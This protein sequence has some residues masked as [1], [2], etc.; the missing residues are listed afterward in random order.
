MCIKKEMGGAGI[1]S[2][3]GLTECPVLAM[4]APSDP[5]EKLAH[6]EGRAN[7]SEFEIRVVKLDGSP[8]AAGEEGEIRARGP[9]LC[10]GYLDEALNADAYDA[11]GFFRTG[12][13]GTLDAEGYVVI[14]GR[15][16][17]VIIRK[18]E[19]IRGRRRGRGRH[20]QKRLAGV[21]P[22]IL[23]TGRQSRAG[24]SQWRRDVLRRQVVAVLG[25][26]LLT[27]GRPGGDDDRGSRL[28]VRRG[29][30]HPGGAHV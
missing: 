27:I 16:K 1:V 14:T 10:K 21:L 17:D 9:Q 25:T 3:Y 23:G 22:R 13:L 19:N 2:G 5:D 24:R 8:A 12:D 11:D 28:G 4:G 30:A 18:G 15:L 29:A 6:T 20:L 26:A 7:P